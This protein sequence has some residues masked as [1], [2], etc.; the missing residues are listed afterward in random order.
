[1]ECPV[2][3]ERFTEAG[4]KQPLILPACGHTIS[5]RAVGT[6]VAQAQLQPGGRKTAVAIKCPC[7]AK[8]QP[9]V[10]ANCSL[11]LINTLLLCT[12]VCGVKRGA[13]GLRKPGVVRNGQA[14]PPI[15]HSCMLYTSSYIP[16][17]GPE[18]L[19]TSSD[20]QIHATPVLDQ[21]ILQGCG[22]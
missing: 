8:R 1:M 15:K 22:L 6:L 5:M 13:L 3:Y 17:L 14:L 10:R 4:E 2:T 21:V 16:S 20:R 11:V 19:Y 9:K 12:T 18:G 7:C